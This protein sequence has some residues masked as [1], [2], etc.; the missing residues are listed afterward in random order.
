MYVYVPIIG[1]LFF[2]LNKP[3]I[4]VFNPIQTLD[5]NV[6]DQHDM[7]KKLENL[8]ITSQNVVLLSL[9]GRAEI[10]VI[11]GLNFWRNDDLINSFW[12]SLTFSVICSSPF[13]GRND[14]RREIRCV[15]IFQQK[16]RKFEC[17]YCVQ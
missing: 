6:L 5:L 3:W 13:C 8:G 7:N 4:L 10:L 17:F 16:F 14:L 12:I 11:L 1:W 15:L 9:F 2:W